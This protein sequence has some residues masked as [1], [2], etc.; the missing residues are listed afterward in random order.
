MS[1]KTSEERWVWVIVQNPD[2][3]AQF[4]GQY[5]E[6]KKISFIPAFLEKE[7]A[8]EALNKMAFE[9][10]HKYE[11]QAIGLD[12]LDRRAAENGFMVFLLSASGKVLEKR[13]GKGEK[14]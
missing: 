9:A 10:G 1:D 12:D 6:E 4:L 8:Q 2:G 11:P 5:D 3:E 7:D 14:R 13:G